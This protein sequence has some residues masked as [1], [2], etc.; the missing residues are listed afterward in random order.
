MQVSHR[1]THRIA[2]ARRTRCH[3]RRQRICIVLLKEAG[4]PVTGVSAEAGRSRVRANIHDCAASQ[5]ST[6]VSGVVHTRETQQFFI[7]SPRN[8]RSRAGASKRDA[9]GFRYQAMKKMPPGSK[10]DRRDQRRAT[11]GCFGCDLSTKH[12]SPRHSRCAECTSW[13]RRLRSPGIHTP[14][15]GYGFRARAFAR[16]GMTKALDWQAT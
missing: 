4:Q 5:R 13:M 15:R 3:G 1:P 7:A 14:C 11:R 16:P 9:G 8:I 12:H 6:V 2:F 10:N